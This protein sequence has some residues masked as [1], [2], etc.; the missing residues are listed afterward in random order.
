MH[1]LGAVM[2]TDPSVI[3]HLIHGTWP[4]GPF[5][6]RPAPGAADA[7]FVDGSEARAGIARHISAKVEWVTFEWS[8]KNSFAARDRAATAFAEHLRAT[9]QQHPG[10]RQVIVAHSH[11]GT[12]SMSALAK[13]HQLSEG[14]AEVSATICLATP[15]AYVSLNTEKQ[16]NMTRLGFL[17]FCFGALWICMIGLGRSSPHYVSIGLALCLVLFAIFLLIYILESPPLPYLAPPSGHVKGKIFVFRSPRDEAAL[18]IGIA[19][20]LHATAARL[21]YFYQYVSRFSSIAAFTIN[22]L[23]ILSVA[24]AGNIL[25]YFFVGANLFDERLGLQFWE[26]FLAGG[27]LWA[28]LS[29][30]PLV[31]THLVLALSTGFTDVRS[32]F[33]ATVEVDAVPL[34]LPVSFQAFRWD[35]PSMNDRTADESGY[36]DDDDDNDDD[37]E[38]RRTADDGGL[39]ASPENAHGAAIALTAVADADQGLRHAIYNLPAVQAEIGRLID[40]VASGRSPKLMTKSPLDMIDFVK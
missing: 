31:A 30:F 33:L 24:V 26:S 4:F 8:G 36:F 3:V 29:W 23:L 27:S 40:I 15:F 37:G 38:E 35:A 5:R 14:K 1:G 6:R 7:W 25:I 22:A 20:A 13:L 18:V 11:G 16:S 17:S 2:E 39:G 32:W 34:D 10:K 19:Q 28:C 9:H 21:S 12:V